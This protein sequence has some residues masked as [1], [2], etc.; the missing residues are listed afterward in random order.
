MSDEAKIVI[1]LKENWATIGVSAPECD[2]V[3]DMAEGDLAEIFAHAAV[4]LERAREQWNTSRRY[5]K[6]DLPPGLCDQ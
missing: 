1:T 4:T 5:P 6:S 2:P 3:F